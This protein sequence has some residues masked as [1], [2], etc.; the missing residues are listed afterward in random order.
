MEAA[1]ELAIAFRRRG[2]AAMTA[3]GANLRRRRNPYFEVLRSYVRWRFIAIA[4]G[5]PAITAMQ[6]A[7]RARDVAVLLVPFWILASPL[8]SHL[9]EMLSGPRSRL[10]PRHVAA[11]FVVAGLFAGLF[12]GLIPLGLTWAFLGPDGPHLS[13]VAETFATFAVAC[14]VCQS[15]RGLSTVVF[16]AAWWMFFEPPGRIVTVSLSMI[17]ALLL[18][19][20]SLLVLM[21]VAVR[22]TSV[23]EVA[24]SDRSALELTGRVVARVIFKFWR[25]PPLDGRSYRRRFV[26]LDVVN[27]ANGGMWRRARHWDAAWSLTHQ[28]VGSG[29]FIGG[30]ILVIRLLLRS[31]DLDLWALLLIFLPFAAYLPSVTFGEP[32]ACFLVGGGRLRGLDSDLSWNW[33]RE[34]GSGG[35]ADGTHQR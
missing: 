8:I 5:V 10:T 20:S 19:A 17:A 30:L 31:V 15:P 6:M 27:L 22:F 4:I 12:V 28:G 13:I 16:M 35:I 14:F 29:L 24:G 34:S 7:H 32:S 9:K 18:L 26:P 1:A 21:V 33:D 2:I 11:H 3:F 23:S 25:R